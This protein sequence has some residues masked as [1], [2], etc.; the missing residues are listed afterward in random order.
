MACDNAG[1]S[2]LQAMLILV[3]PFKWSVWL[4]LAGVLAGYTWMIRSVET[5]EAR[6][7]RSRAL[8]QNSAEGTAAI[9]ADRWLDKVR[10]KREANG[11]AALAS[12]DDLGNSETITQTAYNTCVSCAGVHSENL[13]APGTNALRTI[14]AG[15]IFFIF[16]IAEVQFPKGCDHFLLTV[17]LDNRGHCWVVLRYR[18]PRTMDDAPSS[19]VSLRGRVLRRARTELRCTLFADVRN[20]DAVI[21]NRSIGLRVESDGNLD[22]RA[23]DGASVDWVRQLSFV[24]HRDR[25]QVL[26]AKRCCKRNLLPRNLPAAES[27]NRRQR[28]HPGTNRRYGLIAK[29]CLDAKLTRE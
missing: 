1:K 24:V 9:I 4:V 3:E 29:G 16:L 23:R 25:L 18:L 27:A 14:H 10:K 12:Y 21:T 19:S 7:V 17:W 6:R 13:S 28:K 2:V 11:Q 22:A 15:W 8:G 5:H 20:T 26:R